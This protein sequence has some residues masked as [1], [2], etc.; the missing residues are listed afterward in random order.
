MPR[1]KKVQLQ[2]IEDGQRVACC[3]AWKFSKKEYYT[4]WQHAYTCEVYIYLRDKFIKEREENES[5]K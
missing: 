3:L 5:D 1:K 2:E 4:F